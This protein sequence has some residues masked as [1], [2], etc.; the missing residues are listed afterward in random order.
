MEFAAV[1]LHLCNIASVAAAEL[2]GYHGS[3]FAGSEMI[4]DTCPDSSENFRT[5]AKTSGQGA[6]NSKV[7]L[8]DI[9]T[10]ICL[11]IYI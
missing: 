10:Y 6:V 3:V 9:Y 4:Q 2:G 7:Y 5:F 11:Y 1:Y 8:F